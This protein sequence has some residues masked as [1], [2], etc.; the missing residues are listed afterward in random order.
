M[1]VDTHGFTGWHTTTDDRRP[2]TGRPSRGVP[3]RPAR[4]FDRNEVA[5]ALVTPGRTADPGRAEPPWSCARSGAEGRDGRRQARLLRR[6][7][8]MSRRRFET[9]LGAEMAEDVPLC[10]RTGDAVGR[11]TSWSCTISCRSPWEVRRL[12]LTSAFDARPTIDTRRGRSS[13]RNGSR[14]RSPVAVRLAMAASGPTVG[15]P[16]DAHLLRA[17]DGRTRTPANS[18]RPAAAPKIWANH[19]SGQPRPTAVVGGFGRTTSPASRP[20][21]RGSARRMPG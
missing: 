9:K 21:S 10:P 13:A 16:A 2:T 12:P 18:L 11:T 7:R 8:A 14:A 3:S 4:A 17:V 1:S 20:S 19:E 6:G 5:R 15:K